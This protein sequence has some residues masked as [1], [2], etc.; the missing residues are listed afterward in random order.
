LI[1]DDYGF[2]SVLSSL[3]RNK[4]IKPVHE[5]EKG[6]EE[7]LSLQERIKELEANLAQKK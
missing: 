3:Y 6:E 1:E 4:V 2:K 5:W 7:V